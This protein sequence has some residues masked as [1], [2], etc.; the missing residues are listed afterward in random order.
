MPSEQSYSCRPTVLLPGSLRHI[1]GIDLEDGLVKP[2][3]FGRHIQGI[4]A[5]PRG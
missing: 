1:A 3:V 2:N 5:I 4:D